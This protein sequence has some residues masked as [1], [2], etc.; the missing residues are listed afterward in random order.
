[1]KWLLILTLVLISSKVVAQ[2]PGAPSLVDLTAPKMDD[3]KYQEAVKKADQ[4]LLMQVGVTQAVD[5][6]TGI[7]SN[8]AM[9][10]TSD[11]IDDHT[12]FKHDQ[13]YF[14]LGAAYTMSV[15]HTV[16]ASFQDPIFKKW[17]H[18]INYSP[19]TTQF[20]TNIPF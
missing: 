19:A 18:S 10:F 17:T 1:M 5:K 2:V 15:S 7:L 13:V 16:S 12:P 9:K 4:A 20:V 11:M 8:K 6:Y 14:V 3:P